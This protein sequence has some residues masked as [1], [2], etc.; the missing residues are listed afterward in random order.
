MPRNRGI[1][2]S[3]KR[4]GTNKA[5]KKAPTSVSAASH[6]LL[7]LPESSLPKSMGKP[8][9]HEDLSLLPKCGGNEKSWNSSL[10][11]DPRPNLPPQ[12]MPPTPP[13]DLQPLQSHM[14]ASPEHVPCFPKSIGKQSYLSKCFVNDLLLETSP[15]QSDL[16]SNYLVFNIKYLK[17]HD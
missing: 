10:L 6:Q 16:V 2:S 13:P 14:F 9:P 4:R 8:S 17:Y 7:P 3:R 11:G 12:N 15:K 5:R 1:G